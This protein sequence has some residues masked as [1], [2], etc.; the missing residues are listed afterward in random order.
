MG[1]LT[2]AISQVGKGISKAKH[3]TDT[4]AADAMAVILSGRSDPFELGAF[5][6]AMR[7][8][9]ETATELT[10]FVRVAQN[11]LTPVPGPPPMLTVSS[12]AGKRQT[13]PALIGGACL[14]AACGVTVGIHGH[15]TP[16][17]RTSLADVLAALGGTPTAGP[18]QAA[19][20]LNAAGVAYV[21]IEAFH[22]V[23]WQMLELREKMGLRSCFH[24]MARLVNPYRADNQM[25]GISHARTFEKFSAAS[26][27]LGYRRVVSFRGMEGEAEPNPLTATTGQ[28]LRADG[29]VSDFAIDPAT[30]GIPKASRTELMADTPQQGAELI[31]TALSGNGPQ[32]A[33]DAM[34]LT[35][36]L[37]LL[38][39]EQVADIA[40]G[41]ARARSALARG[42]GADRLN[43]WCDG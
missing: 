40:D 3:L 31:R 20:R 17:E 24:T 16:P 41:L 1:Q 33:R 38:A 30:L 32:I 39:A 8:K 5:L 42:K 22:P 6:V 37:G 13:F 35:A 19:S 15:G 12:Y 23:M 7:I 28:M 34:A 25:V 9:E 18:E 21:G 11:G 29:R 14:M 2:Q 27:A 26:H 36:A 43:A 4:E 10:A